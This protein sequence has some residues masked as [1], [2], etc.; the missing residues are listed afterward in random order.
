MNIYDVI[1]EETAGRVEKAAVV[2]GGRQ[3]SY[4]ELF[5]AVDETARE[6][7]ACGL[8]PSPIPSPG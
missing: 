3:V 5:T 2:D 1:R 7:N 8:G 6:L 4:E